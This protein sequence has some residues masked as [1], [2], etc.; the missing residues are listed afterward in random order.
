[1]GSTRHT[2]DQMESLLKEWEVSNDQRAVFLS[3][4]LLMTRSM[5]VAMDQ[6]EFKDTKWVDKLLQ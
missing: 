4:Y 6:G 2:T 5:V 1:M 3:C